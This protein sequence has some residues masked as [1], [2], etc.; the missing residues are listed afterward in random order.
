VLIA[1]S[2]VQSLLWCFDFR[3][4]SHDCRDSNLPTK[5]MMDSAAHVT[6]IAQIDLHVRFPRSAVYYVKSRSLRCLFLWKCGK[7]AQSEV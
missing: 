2:P 6:V 5:T 1:R 4:E 3:V 7:A